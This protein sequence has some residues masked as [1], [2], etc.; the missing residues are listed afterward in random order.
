MKKLHLL[1]NHKEMLLAAL[2]GSPAGQTADDVLRA[3]DIQHKLKACNGVLI[4]EDAEYQRVV[5]T[6]NAPIFRLA[7]D[8]TADFIKAVR[9]ATDYKLEPV[10]D[11]SGNEYR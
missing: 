1:E 2:G 7:N 10:L 8:E 4:L 3:V 11:I 9:G 6:L 5:S